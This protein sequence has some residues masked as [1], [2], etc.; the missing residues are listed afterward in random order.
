MKIFYF[1]QVT[2]TVLTGRNDVREVKL[3]YNNGTLGF[4]QNMI[5]VESHQLSSLRDVSWEGGAAQF[6]IWRG[7]ITF[8]YVPG[9]TIF[10]RIQVTSGS[11]SVF[12]K[13]GACPTMSDSTCEDISVTTNIFGQW[14]W[15]DSDRVGFS[16]YA[17]L[18]SHKCGDSY[19]SQAETCDDGNNLSGSSYYNIFMI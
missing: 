19:I 10:Y 6:D 14:I 16:N 15:T 11:K 1:S 5:K 8:R 17:Y 4:E 12:L 13:S 18:I 7:N 9:N 2:I 3:L